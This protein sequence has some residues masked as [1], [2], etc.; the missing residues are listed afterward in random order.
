MCKFSECLE[1][2]SGRQCRCAVLYGLW[3]QTEGAV[4]RAERNQN[5]Y[6]RP[7]SG[8]IRTHLWTI[9]PTGRGESA[10]DG[11]STKGSHQYVGIAKQEEGCSSVSLSITI[12]P[13]AEDPFFFTVIRF[14]GTT[15]ILWK[16]FKKSWPLFCS[17]LVTGFLR[18][19]PL[20]VSVMAVRIR[21]RISKGISL[22]GCKSL[23]VFLC[24]SN[25]LWFRWKQLKIFI[26]QELAC[27]VH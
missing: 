5:V 25:N 11:R 21:T 19:L 23:L 26:L 2:V 14:K 18:P 16:M 17:I 6:R 15:T 20:P 27:N 4:E 12:F 13:P 10:I 3:W 22:K 7:N 24:L 9:A 1:V 8:L